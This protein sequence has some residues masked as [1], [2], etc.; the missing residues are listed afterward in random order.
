MS[1]KQSCTLAGAQ[2][3]AIF[4]SK[5]HLLEPVE[6]HAY[7]FFPIEHQGSGFVIYQF[8]WPVLSV[9]VK[10]FDELCLGAWDADYRHENMGLPSPPP[11]LEQCGKAV[12]SQRQ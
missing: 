9:T 11:P 8:L 1:K 6:S 4:T 12:D 3:D 5:T 7:Y 2:N 10:L